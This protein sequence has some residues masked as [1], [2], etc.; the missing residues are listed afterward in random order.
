MKG[1]SF[2]TKI[3]WFTDSM[4][5]SDDGEPISGL[6]EDNAILNFYNNKFGI[7]GDWMSWADR[8]TGLYDGNHYVDPYSYE[9][10]IRLWYEAG[11]RTGWRI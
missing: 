4:I 9:N 3:G 11:N 10:T 6:P 1:E 2:P 7:I 5:L 8:I